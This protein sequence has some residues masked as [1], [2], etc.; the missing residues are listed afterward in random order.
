MTASK[1][2]FRDS[3]LQELNSPEQ[4]DKR[5]VVTKPAGWLGLLAGLVIIVS[6][7]TWGFLGSVDTKVGGQG[8]LLNP[9]G[10]SI[11]ESTGTGTVKL[12]HVREGDSVAKGDV[13]ATLDIPVLKD[14]VDNALA[15]VHEAKERRNRLA[16]SQAT[17]TELRKDSIAS[18]TRTLEAD[19]HA[20]DSRIG[21]IEGR[22]SDRTELFNDGLITEEQLYLTKTDLAAANNERRKIDDALAEMS[23]QDA[24]DTHRSQEQ[25]WVQEIAIQ[26]AE[27]LWQRL[28]DDYATQVRVVSQYTGKIIEITTDVGREVQEQTSIVIVEPEDARIEAVVYVSSGN[29]KKIREGMPIYLSPSTVK[30]EEHGLMIGR[31][32]QVSEFPVTRDGMMALLGNDEL[33]N[34]FTRD[35]APIAVTAHLT[36]DASTASGFKWTSGSG[37]PMRIGDG[38][39]CSA[40]VTVERRAP[41]DLV[42]PY[43]KSSLGE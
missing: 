23:L 12:L 20:I 6:A 9:Q 29:G 21:L 36:L 28:S 25:L 10:V 32:Q 2:L 35:G 8:I 5:L 1:N 39:P 42:I 7:A 34:E 18:R 37:A 17:E 31:V 11:V 15:L 16:D 27:R 33:V 24:L 40:E 41:I 13:V 3:A 30:K 4:L 14:K 22:L 43:L 26:D 38:T 19:A